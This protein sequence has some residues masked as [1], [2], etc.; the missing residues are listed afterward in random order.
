[1]KDSMYPI[2]EELLAELRHEGRLLDGDIIEVRTST[3]ARLDD[4]PERNYHRTEYQVRVERVHGGRPYFSSFWISEV[5]LDSYGNAMLRHRLAKALELDPRPPQ[6]APEQ[7]ASVER[8][9]FDPVVPD[10][11]RQAFKGVVW[12]REPTAIDG[13]HVHRY[14][15]VGVLLTSKPIPGFDVSEII[16][17]GRSPGLAEA[18]GQAELGGCNWQLGDAND[19][20]CSLDS[21]TAQSEEHEATR[22]P[23]ETW[24][25][26][27]ARWV[28]GMGGDVP[29]ELE[30]FDRLVAKKR[31][32]PCAVAMGIILQAHWVNEG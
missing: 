6:E 2:T 8:S 17:A 5:Q 20:L 32:S 27:V 10:H 12:P 3:T 21:I 26:L 25:E 1:M 19:V 7:R 15:V 18:L 28:E 29:A 22:R 4:D 14:A 23:G 31:K 24:R 30:I 11:P 9:A 13:E 16:L